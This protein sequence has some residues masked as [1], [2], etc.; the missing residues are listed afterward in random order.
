MSRYAK[1]AAAGIIV[2]M[3]ATPAQAALDWNS[4]WHTADQRGEE[5]LKQGDAA[6]AARIYS[7]PR[8]KAYAELKAGDN[9]AAARDFSAFQD[10]DAHYDRGNALARAGQLQEALKAYDDAL[11]QNPDNKDARHNR[12]LVEKAL[13][14][15]Q[16]QSKNDQSK[17]GQSGDNK[18]QNQ[19]NS[20]DGKSQSGESKNS[21]NGQQQSQQSDQKAQNGSSGQSQS[22]AGGDKD[23]SQRQQ[24]QAQQQNKPQSNSQSEPQQNQQGEQ[25]SAGS[26]QQA[27]TEPD[28][29]PSAQDEAA[30]AR[31]DAE[32]GLKPQQAQ[33]QSAASAAG[34]EALQS[35][36][37]TSS[38]DNAAPL[39]EQQLAEQ[40]W[41][42]RIPDDPGGLLRRK[43]MVEHMLRQ[44]Q[45]QQ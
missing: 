17:N 42:R 40:Q 15:Q 23:Q 1:G 26:P 37:A 29:T 38:R 4:L 21:R 14:Q 43:F 13:E 5:L 22:S 39:T 32:A 3:L 6:G 12:D 7:D 24:N 8:R 10:S 45:D 31:R 36:K 18:D 41:L 20:Q 30:Q 33:A 2:L 35:G 27:Q 11:K 44:Q 34:E 9:A 28:K 25:R 19:Q 16:Q